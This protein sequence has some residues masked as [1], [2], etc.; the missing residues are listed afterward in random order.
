MERAAEIYH[1]ALL[2]S[3]DAGEARG[4]LRQRGFDGDM[5]RRYQVGFAPDSWDYLARR[6][7]ISDK[8]LVDLS[9]IHI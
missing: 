4:Y 8:D 1:E 5:V 7:K 2:S 6:L 9:L 3:P